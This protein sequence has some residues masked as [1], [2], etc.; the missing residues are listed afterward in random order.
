VICK[1]EHNFKTCIF[2]ASFVFCGFFAFVH[3]ANAATYY[4]DKRCSTNGNGSTADCANGATGPINTT[5]SVGATATIPSG[6]TSTIILA[7]G[8]S[9][10]TSCYNPFTANQ[11][12]GTYTLMG[13]SNWICGDTNLNTATYAWHLS[14]WDHDSNPATPA[15]TYYLTLANG[16]APFGDG[17]TVGTYM[18]SAIVNGW[19]NS[20]NSTNLTPVGFT[21]TGHWLSNNWAYGDYDS[22]GY[23]TFYVR[24]ENG[25]D[26]TGKNPIYGVIT[27]V[28]RAFRNNAGSSWNIWNLNMSGSYANV[29]DSAGTG[30]TNI[31]NS[32]LGGADGAAV[33]F[34]GTGNGSG[35]YYSLIQ[36][37]H[38]GIYIDGD[39]DVTAMNNTFVG[40]HLAVWDNHNSNHVLVFKNNL[41]YANVAGGIYK[42]YAASTLDE[43]NNL[44]NLDSVTTHS[45]AAIGYQSPTTWGTTASSD[46]PASTN[47]QTACPTACGT[48]PLVTSSSNFILLPSS[49]AINAGTNLGLTSDI[50]GNPIIGLPDIGAYEY[51]PSGGSSRSNLT[52]SAPTLDVKE[53]E[54]TLS[55]QTQNSATYIISWT[56]KNTGTPKEYISLEKNKNFSH[57]ISNLKPNTSY[58]YILDIKNDR[59]STRLQGEFKTLLTNQ[60]GKTSTSGVS[61]ISVTTDPQAQ[62][63]ELIKLLNSLIIK[64]VEKFKGN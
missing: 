44:F 20:A 40:N 42:T 53:T 43:S 32:V 28:P 50:N 30:V 6:E 9:S 8:S 10:R 45:G 26:P 47:T 18:T 51:Q 60:G 35:I 13:N 59:E 39:V 34:G 38:R 22:L 5:T 27:Q 37:G 58:T 41:T 56:E 54:A 64:L 29:L 16:S 46:I 62:L 36:H 57:T 15:D 1:A 55:W 4:V 7:A 23:Q 3:N 19:W 63:K 21:L 11:T 25:E 61:I 24:Y 33:H 52:V 48:D 49:L 12:S 17:A 14:T 2:L 31:Y